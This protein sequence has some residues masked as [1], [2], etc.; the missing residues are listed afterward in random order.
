MSF[1]LICVCALF[2]RF[3]SCLL[4]AAMKLIEL[5]YETKRCRPGLA[6]FHSEFFIQFNSSFFYLFTLYRTLTHYYILD[7][8]NNNE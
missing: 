8:K 3:P 5:M 2:K 1:D 7:I 4:V 6:N